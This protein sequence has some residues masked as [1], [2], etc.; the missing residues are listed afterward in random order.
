[1]FACVVAWRRMQCLLRSSGAPSC[2]LHARVFSCRACL[3]VLVCCRKPHMSL[4]PVAAVL[5]A[6]TS[7]PALAARTFT[8]SARLFT[9]PHG[10]EGTKYVRVYCAYSLGRCVAFMIHKF[11][12]FTCECSL[13]CLI[14][15]HIFW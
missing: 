6:V 15:P 14:T 11:S 9:E 2:T 13:V 10:G 8:S 1:V 7:Q 3:S 12:S 4:R 5:R